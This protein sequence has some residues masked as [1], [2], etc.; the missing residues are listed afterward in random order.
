VQ[1][2]GTT[3]EKEVVVSYTLSGG[4]TSLQG[5]G[6]ISKVDAGGTTGAT[7][8]VEG[9]PDTGVPLTLQV[10]VLPVIGE[11]IFDN[12]AATYTV[13]FGQ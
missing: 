1:N 8:R 11:S 13:T 10:E 6:T 5:E 2:Q 3:Q 9:E 7:I 4:G 12:N